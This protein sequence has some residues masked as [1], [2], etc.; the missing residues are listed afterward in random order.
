M[1]IKASNSAEQQ[2][3]PYAPPGPNVILFRDFTAGLNTEA[4]RPG[5]ENNQMFICDGWFPLGEGNARVMPGIG[6]A[7]YTV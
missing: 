6:P 4:S 1:P 7:L 2:E 3:T 5:I